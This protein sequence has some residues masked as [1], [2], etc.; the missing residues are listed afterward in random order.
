MDTIPSSELILNPDGSVYHLHLHPEQLSDTIITVGDPDRV[1]QV[2]K[3]FDSIEFDQQK[4][5]FRTVTGK[6]K[7]KRITVIS[8]GIGTDNIDIVFNELD[9]LVNIDFQSRK[10]KSTHTQL[11]FIRIGTSGTIQSTIPVDSWL[12]SAYAIGLDNL[13]HFYDSEA[14]RDIPL[15]QAFK[16]TVSWSKNLQ[17]YCVAANADLLQHMASDRCLQGIT[18]TNAGFY[19]PQGRRLRLAPSFTTFIKDLSAFQYQHQEGDVARTIPQ[20]TNLEMET[21]GIYGLARLLGHR[22]ISLNAILANRALGTFSKNPATTVDTLIIY[23]LDR[24]LTL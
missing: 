5:E 7:G 23:T 19:G 6:Y 3:H 8:T 14:V 11:N 1:S 17:P 10:P 18:M 12:I 21:S 2:S 22:A 20:I 13:L 15:E 24:L 4:R 16:N 9:A